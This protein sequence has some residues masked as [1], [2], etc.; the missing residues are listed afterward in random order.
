[1]RGLSVVHAAHTVGA[2]KNV[3]WRTT[4][5]PFLLHRRN[6][7]PHEKCPVTLSRPTTSVANKENTCKNDNNNNNI[8]TRNQ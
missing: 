6:G 8:N 3:S 4:M 1:M 2:V 7:K 5:R